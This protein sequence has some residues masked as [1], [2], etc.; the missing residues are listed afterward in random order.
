MTEDVRNIVREEVRTAFQQ[1]AM[2]IGRFSPLD[3][4]GDINI[5][6]PI[7]IVE[8]QN[9]LRVERQ[10]TADKSKQIAELEGLIRSKNDYIRT[11]KKTNDEWENAPKGLPKEWPKGFQAVL[12]ADGI[13]ANVLANDAT[14]KCIVGYISKVTELKKELEEA[15]A[16]PQMVNSTVRMPDGTVIEALL[17]FSAQR[18]IAEYSAAL[19]RLTAE[20]EELKKVK[21]AGYTKLAEKSD[22]IRMLRDKLQRITDAIS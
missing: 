14:V 1:I 16:K 8:L 19:Y 18:C 11:L 12:H 6:L 2:D 10:M 5:Q 22:E 21:E 4:R 13:K 3:Y 7:K 15:R 20:Y 9:E 17:T